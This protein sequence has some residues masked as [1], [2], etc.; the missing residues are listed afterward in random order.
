MNRPDDARFFTE[1]LMH[2][3]RETNDRSLPWKG[4]KDPYRIW[5]SEIIL[6]QTRAEQG[7]PYYER[8]LEAYPT[9]QALAAAPDDD[10]F[11]LWQ[12]LGY[13]NRCRNL[14]HTARY[15]AGALGGRF[16]DSYDGLLALKGIGSYTAAAIASFAFGLPHAVVDGNVYRVLARYFGLFV[17]TDST[18]GKKLF[19]RKADEALDRSD[20]GGYNQAIMDHGATVC[21]PLAPRCPAC[22]VQARC[23]A[24]RQGV[25]GELPV[26]KGKAALRQ[27]H[28]HYLVLVHDGR[29]WLRKRTEGIWASL[30]EPFL[31]EADGPL[32]RTA[33]QE[34]DAIRALALPPGALQYEGALAR[35]LSHQALD[36]RFFSADVHEVPAVLP[37]DGLWVPQAALGQYA[38][39]KALELFFTRKEYF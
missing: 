39:P 16:P 9:V 25:I 24:Y 14:L 34:T 38:L 4:L 8:F 6:Q 26:R 19:A 17:V 7:R 29:I 32:D 18:E 28:L 20:P 37:E 23:Y 30:Y 31:L 27:R 2:W 22:P 11:R 35:K 12:G 10:V 3:H 1:N 33:L 5:L 13:Y 36:I 15:V 21:T